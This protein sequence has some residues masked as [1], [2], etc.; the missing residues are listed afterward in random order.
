MKVRSGGNQ[1]LSLLAISVPT[2]FLIA[3]YLHIYMY[4]RFLYRQSTAISLTDVTSEE[5][6][7]VASG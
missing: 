7:P 6:S 2:A 1:I 5:Y 3:H 4:S